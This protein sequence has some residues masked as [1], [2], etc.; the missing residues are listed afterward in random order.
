MSLVVQVF[1][2]DRRVGECL[3]LREE[4]KSEMLGMI[5]VLDPERTSRNYPPPTSLEGLRALLVESELVIVHAR[6]RLIRATV[7]RNT[8]RHCRTRWLP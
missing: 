3:L 7:E 2:R 4:Q 6:C 1:G 5:S 8:S